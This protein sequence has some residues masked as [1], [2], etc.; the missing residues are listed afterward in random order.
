VPS[1]APSGVARITT[2]LPL[3]LPLPLLPPPLPLPLTRA[4]LAR[5]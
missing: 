4:E 2:P 3:P 5:V 1:A